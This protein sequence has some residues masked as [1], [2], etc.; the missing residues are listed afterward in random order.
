[1]GGDEIKSKLKIFIVF[2][3]IAC[4][5]LSVKTYAADV[6]DMEL[7]TISNWSEGKGYNEDGKM[8]KGTWA[9]DSGNPAGKYV[10]FDEEGNVLKKSDQWEKREDSE[11]NF[12]ATEQDPATIALRVESFPDFCGT[13]Y[14]VIEEKSGAQKKY[15]LNQ[16]NHYELNIKVNSDSFC[17]KS[18][19]AQDTEYEYKTVFSPEGY[20]VEKESLKIVK[21]QVSEEKTQLQQKSEQQDDKREEKNPETN[22]TEIKKDYHAKENK[23]MVVLEEKKKLLIFSGIMAIGILC[24]LVLKPK[25]N[26]YQ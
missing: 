16:D 8:L 24:Y 4:C 3:F 7:P 11:D 15:E 14:V 22:Q 12:T 23:E 21:I 10:L 17:L 18:V 1:M 13:V 6:E 19:N 2:F 5:L 25:K 9:Y 20:H 26:K